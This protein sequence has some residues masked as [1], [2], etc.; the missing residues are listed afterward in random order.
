MQAQAVI[1]NFKPKCEPLHE[2]TKMKKRGELKYTKNGRIKNILSKIN[3][4]E[5]PLLVYSSMKKMIEDYSDIF[6]IEDEKLTHNN[7][8]SQNI[9]LKDQIPVYI[10]NYKPIHSQGAEI[11]NQIQKLLDDD[12]IEPS[13]SA[14]NSPILLVP[15]KSRSKK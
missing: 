4:K 11:T 3:F 14:Y 7:F 15:K 13:I 8:Y 2:Y 5:I 12:I 6:G 9:L 1:S 10:P